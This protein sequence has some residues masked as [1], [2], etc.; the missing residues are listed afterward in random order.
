MSDGQ[1]IRSVINWFEIPASDFERAAG[2]YEKILAVKLKRERMGGG[3]M[4]VFPYTRPGVSGAI[5]DVPALAGQP[6]G[7]VVYLNCD[8]RLDAVAARVEEAGGALL[9]PRVDLP[10]GMGAFFHIRDSEGNRVGL[11]GMTK[12]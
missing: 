10:E 8:D 9:T 11:H 5:M 1:D 7:T 4:A 2:F 12:G 6:T 3:R